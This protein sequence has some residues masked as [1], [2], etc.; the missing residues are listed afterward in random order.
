MSDVYR[1][2]VDK[3]RAKVNVNEEVQAHMDVDDICGIIVTKE[4]Q[5][6]MLICYHKLY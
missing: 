2:N 3:N 4:G 6:M 5:F 1:F